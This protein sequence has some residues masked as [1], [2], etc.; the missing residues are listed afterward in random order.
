MTVGSEVRVE[1]RGDIVVATIDRPRKLNAATLEVY[2]RLEQALSVEAAGYVVTGAAGQFSAGDD[3][4]MFSFSGRAAADAFIVD[5]T[6]L[7]QMVEGIP[8]PV[9]AA[10]DGYALGFGFELALV[11]DVIVATPRA[12]FGLPE[13]TH[14]A[15]PPNAM[16]R[17]V[18]V[19]GRGLVRHMAL[20]GRRWLSGSDAHRHGLV[21]ELHPPERL[22]DAAVKLA[23]EMAV[24]PGFTSAKRLLNLWGEPA[25][26]LAPMVM[27]RL[28]ASATVAA[29]A[30][31]FDGDG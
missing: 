3:V 21:A 2:R 4:G 28:M 20:L 26:R 1:R 23:G 12:V 27:P 11:S 22:V 7:F 30:A 10:V 13:I 8:R 17:A 14:G 6:K 19:I 18:D 9:V 5:V 16:G 31:S 24:Q 29:S 25:F 15:A